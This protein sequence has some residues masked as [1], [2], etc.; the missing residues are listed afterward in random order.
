MKKASMEALVRYLN[1]ETVANLDV[2]RDE[3]V[4]ELAKDQ[5][6]AEANRTLYDQIGEAVL[7]ALASTTVPVTAQ[8]L[9]DET[10]FPKGKIV[11]GLRNYWSDKVEKT[12]GKV[13]TYTLK[14]EA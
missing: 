13:N 7:K 8:E 4:A 6:K 3:L 1:G 9:A 12:A 5:A 2:I 11:Y 14:E 10:G